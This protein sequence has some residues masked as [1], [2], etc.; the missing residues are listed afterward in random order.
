MRRKTYYIIVTLL[1][2]MLF[3]IQAEAAQTSISATRTTGGVTYTVASES[4]TDISATRTEYFID[5]T[6]Q[7]EYMMNSYDISYPLYMSGLRYHEYLNGYFNIRITTSQSGASIDLSKALLNFPN[8]EGIKVY[9]GLS[10]KT[11]L[12]I[13]VL[14]DNYYTGNTVVGL[15]QIEC[16]YTQGRLNPDYTTTYSNFTASIAFQAGA[17]TSTEFP[18]DQGNY[19]IINDAII[20]ALHES[21]E[22]DDIITLLTT[23]KDQDPVYYSQIVTA[24]G[25]LHTDNL[26]ILNEVDLDFQQV[27]TILDLF[28]SYRT[29]VLQYWQELLAMN[30]SQASQAAE[31]ESQYADQGAQSETILNGLNSLNLPDVDANDFNLLG[32]VDSTQKTNF[33]GLISLITNNSIVTTLLLIIVTGAIVGYI[34]YGKK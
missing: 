12:N 34:L 31:M 4:Y 22:F 16:T 15:G 5:E 13:Y 33:F 27:Q 17:V 9:L 2:V 18:L 11:A 20:E 7:N 23:I 28:P 1:F 8:T 10:T 29:Q 24:L 3:G 21:T 14:F 6:T 30:A 19:N 26:N 32:Q 25:Q